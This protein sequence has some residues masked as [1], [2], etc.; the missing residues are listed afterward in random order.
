MGKASNPIALTPC[1]FLRV[2]LR[3]RASPDLAVAIGSIQLI[4]NDRIDPGPSLAALAEVLSLCRNLESLALDGGAFLEDLCHELLSTR[5]SSLGSIKYVAVGANNTAPTREF[6]DLVHAMPQLQHCDGFPEVE[7][8]LALG[9]SMHVAHKH[10][11][12]LHVH[13]R[14]AEIVGLLLVTGR[15]TAQTVVF[16]GRDPAG[17]FFLPS[18]PG[19]PISKLV[20][21]RSSNALRLEATAA[22][23]IGCCRFIRV[24]HITATDADML[25]LLSTFL[26]DAAFRLRELALHIPHLPAP[27]TYGKDRVFLQIVALILS[28]PST[29]SRLQSLR[30][31]LPIPSH[32]HWFDPLISLCRA[33]RIAYTICRSL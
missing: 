21:R 1:N 16:S 8:I 11:R 33:R 17:W 29:L 18:Y 20:I 13:P 12:Q 30:I 2:P 6:L 3:L 27:H 32:D 23:V 7:N 24:L 14:S 28:M 31:C 10:F 9:E 19:L 15:W 4:I 26:P 22:F 5:P 25:A